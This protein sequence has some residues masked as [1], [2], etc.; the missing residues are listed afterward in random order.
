MAKNVARVLNQLHEEAEEGHWDD[1][2]KK[3]T[4]VQGALKLIKQQVAK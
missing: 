3:L 1:V 2:A 4:Q